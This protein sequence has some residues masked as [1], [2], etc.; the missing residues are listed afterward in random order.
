[1]RTLEAVVRLGSI[2]RAT[3]ALHLTR[4]TVSAQ[5]HELQS[6]L[7]TTLVEPVGRGI[8]TTE[9]ARLLRETALDIFAR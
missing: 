5:V 2:T 9:A 7:D 4:P 6:A 8:R 3:A 1:M